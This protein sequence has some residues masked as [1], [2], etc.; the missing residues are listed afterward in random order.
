MTKRTGYFF[1]FLGLLDVEILIG[2]FV[3]D[4]FIRPY[5]GDILVT[6]LLCCLGRAIVSKEFPW[7]PAAVFGFSV[8]VEC[9]Q[10]ID[11]PALNGTLLGII[12][13]STFDWADI[14]C[15]GIGCLIF[16]AAEHLLF[17][18]KAT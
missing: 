17:Q 6:A 11:I 9:A 3:R 16:W 4:A 2:A 12:L 10:T 14:L 13:G 18:R 5:V 7:L 15:Y 1:A 8:I